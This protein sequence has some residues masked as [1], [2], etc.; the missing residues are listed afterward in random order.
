MNETVRALA[1]QSAEHAHRPISLPLPTLFA[2]MPITAVASIAH[3]VTGIVLFAGALFLFYLLSTALESE[4]GF[5]AARGIIQAP[6]GKFALWLIL[7]AL[8]F[9]LFAGIKHLF[10][11]FHIGDSMRGG[12]LGALLSFVLA[13]VVAIAAGVW[14]W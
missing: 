10:M 7:V 11:D 12:R 13:L 14:L 9:H 2:A 8:A 4:A 6:L 3:R 5:D 1:P